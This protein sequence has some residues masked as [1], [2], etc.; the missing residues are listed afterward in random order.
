MSPSGD[1]HTGS[2]IQRLTLSNCGS[3]L[4]CDSGGSVGSDASERPLS[5]HGYLHNFQL[6][7]LPVGAVEP[8]RGCESGGSGENAS[9]AAAFAASP[10]L[11]SS[12][13]LN[14]VQHEYRSA[15]RPPRFVFDLDLRRPV[16]HAGRNSIL[17]WGVNRQDAGLAAPRHGWRVAAAP[18][19]NVGLRACRA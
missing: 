3:W 12:H 17:I 4:A 6:T 10:G 11:D 19:I 5:Q 16:N 13:I 2:T 9:S 14:R 7:N 1:I 18:Q 15:L 8:R